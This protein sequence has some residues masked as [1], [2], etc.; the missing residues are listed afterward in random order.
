MLGDVESD[1]I[2]GLLNDSDNDRY[3]SEQYM[4]ILILI[5]ITINR[6]VGGDPPY[7]ELKTIRCL[8][9]YNWGC[10]PPMGAH[11]KK[12][13]AIWSG[14]QWKIATFDPP[15]ATLLIPKY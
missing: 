10:Y 6:P 11:R 12:K 8:L 9:P 4:L 13:M 1:T 15:P 14:K 5:L 2:P 3:R 7:R